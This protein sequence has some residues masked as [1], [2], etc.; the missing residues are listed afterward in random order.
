MIYGCLGLLVSLCKVN[1][2]PL[3]P[4]LQSHLV[5]MQNTLM[6]GSLRWRGPCLLCAATFPATSLSSSLGWA[7]PG[8]PD[9]QRDPGGLTAPV[10]PVG[11]PG[12]VAGGMEKGW[13][14]VLRCHINTG[15]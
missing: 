10:S 1:S 2:F 11:P 14:T 5:P 9:T 6:R 7:G 15:C 13:R 3:S 4:G 12:A 8:D